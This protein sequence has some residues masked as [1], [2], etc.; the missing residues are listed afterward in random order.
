[1]CTRVFIHLGEVIVDAGGAAFGGGSGARFFFFWL[2][3]IVLTGIAAM[4]TTYFSPAVEG[5]GIPVRREA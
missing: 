5:S 4:L 3:D 1:M 2:Y